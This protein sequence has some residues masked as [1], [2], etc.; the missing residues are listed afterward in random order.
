MCGIVGYVG[1]RPA[2][3]VVMDA[4]RRRCLAPA[5]AHC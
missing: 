3:V 2:Y 5:L 1:R 4:L